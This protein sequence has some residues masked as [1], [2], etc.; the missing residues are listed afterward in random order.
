MY[1]V[2]SNYSDLT[3]PIS[4]KCWFSKG[5]S[6]KNQENLGRGEMLFHLARCIPPCTL[7]WLTKRALFLV[8]FGSK[9]KRA[10]LGWRIYHEQMVEKPSFSGEK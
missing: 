4:P 8:I 7:V 6:Q 9:S 3:R 10:Q 5:N 2:W 1:L